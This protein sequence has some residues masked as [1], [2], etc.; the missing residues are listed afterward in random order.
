MRMLTLG[1]T[2][3]MLASMGLVVMVCCLH[4]QQHSCDGFGA[5]VVRTVL[6]PTPT[7]ATRSPAACTI[8]SR[9][10]TTGSRSRIYSTSRPDECDET[11]KTTLEEA[12]NVRAA[13]SS[14]SLARRQFFAAASSVAVV[15]S[16]SL[17]GSSSA[18]FA[19]DA[20]PAAVEVVAMKDF[21]DPKGLFKLQ[22]PARFF[23]LRRTVK[24]DLPDE[25]T[26]KDGR[27]GSSIF[28][29]GDMAKAEVIAVERYPARLLLEEE[30]FVMSEQ[31][32]KFDT[33]SKLGKPEAVAQLIMRRRERDRPGQTTRTVV[34]KDSV[35]LSEDGKSLMFKTS[36]DIDIQ[37]P[38][39]L[40]EQ[41]GVDRLS[42]ISSAKATLTPSADVDSP[43]TYLFMIVFASA[44]EMD[45]LG[46]DGKALQTSVDSFVP[47]SPP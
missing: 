43:N 38:E 41:M 11:K 24:G 36:T 42:R 6:A 32:N 7:A 3:S 46:P 20:A 21:V 18:A 4:L 12:S 17:L 5:T 14:S 27:R 13:A 23:T 30:G 28:T 15:G 40:M 34:V 25:K 9:S 33:I 1:P 45:Y 8:A 2:T 37:K 10:G 35:H 44:L 39:L 22:V 19:A 29:A 26:G 31:D 47:T 16:W